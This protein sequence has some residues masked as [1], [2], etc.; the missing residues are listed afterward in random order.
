MHLLDGES[1]HFWPICTVPFPSTNV[2]NWGASHFGKLI[3]WNSNI[4]IR[5]CIAGIAN[6]FLGC[7]DKK[8]DEQNI[9]NRIVIDRSEAE[10]FEFIHESC[11]YSLLF[12]QPNT[13]Y[14]ISKHDK[15][16]K[17]IPSPPP[18]V[19]AITRSLLHPDISDAEDYNCSFSHASFRQPK[20]LR[21]WSRRLH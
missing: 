21:W 14:I 20:S 4:S 12:F 16:H 19:V 17:R 1:T 11:V 6:L 5:I 7:D 10:K 8:I 15:C 3:F 2:F 13:Y 9:E 18:D